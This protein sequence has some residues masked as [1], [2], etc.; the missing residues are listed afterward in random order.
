MKKICLFALA[1]FTIALVSNA[2]TQKGWYMIGGNISNIGLDFQKGNT[3]FKFDL[4]PRV[5]WFVKDDLAIG[6]QVL[7][8]YNTTKGSN[9]FNY[10]IGPV[11]RYYLPG[12]SLESVNNTRLFLD[13]DLGLY[14]NNNK[15]GTTS[16]STNG[17][18]IGVGPGLAYFISE[19]IALEGLAKYRLSAG[20]GNSPVTHSINLGIGFQIHLPSSKLKEMRGDIKR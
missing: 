20:F 6:G 9:M 5:A 16:T 7:L 13:G 18:G 19:N 10:G 4:T 3:A 12:K 11:V 15:T 14:G 17:I 1:L 8:G 2:Q